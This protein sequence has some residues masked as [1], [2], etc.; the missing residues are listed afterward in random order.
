MYPDSNTILAGASQ[1]AHWSSGVRPIPYT[2]RFFAGQLI[3][4]TGAWMQRTA[5]GWLA[6]LILGRPQL[7]A[8]GNSQNRFQ[9]VKCS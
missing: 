5:Q 2:P 4:L 7:K 8:G 6:C 1:L 9:F 3:S